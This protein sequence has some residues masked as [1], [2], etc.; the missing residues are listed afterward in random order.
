MY[1]KESEWNGDWQRLDPQTNGSPLISEHEISVK[2]DSK[3]KNSTIQYCTYG[4][5]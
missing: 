4:Q 1:P 2:Q 3:S 5:Q